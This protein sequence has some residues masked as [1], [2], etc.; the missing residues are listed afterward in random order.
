[1][2]IVSPAKN[3]ALQILP[4]FNI[5]EYVFF[6]C[7][8]GPPCILSPQISIF[9]IELRRVL[10]IC[11]IWKMTDSHLCPCHK[12]WNEDID[13]AAGIMDKRDGLF[14]DRHTLT[15]IFH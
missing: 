9:F 11:M 15:A 8:I 10:I 1:M 13:S 2:T 7:L 6:I 3:A 5:F 12:Y 4:D 14:Q